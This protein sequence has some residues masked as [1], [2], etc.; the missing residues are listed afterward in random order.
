MFERLSRIFKGKTTK[1]GLIR[2]FQHQAEVFDVEHAEE[3]YELKRIK[4]RI[5][6]ILNRGKQAAQNG[7]TLGKRQAGMELKGVQMEAAQVERNLMKVINA[8]TF[9]R[10]ML[11]RLE[12][13]GRAQLGRA[14]E[15]LGKLMK[16]PEFQHLMAEAR[17]TTQE[18][19]GKIAAAVDR[20]F[21]EQPEEAEA[22]KVDTSIFDDLAEA[23][24]TGNVDKVREIKRK[25]GARAEAEVT[26]DLAA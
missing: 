26:D 25:A 7:D 20:V 5:E 9:V 24:R 13:C 18:A 21:E 2:Q 4:A 19:E 1:E 23:D 14:Y 15:R 22:L 6:G 8:R 10:L 11:G 16:D 3:N 17:Y 12:R